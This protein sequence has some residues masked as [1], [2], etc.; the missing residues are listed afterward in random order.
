[1]QS[2]KC[3]VIFLCKAFISIMFVNTLFFG[4]FFSDDGTCQHYINK[5]DCKTPINKALGSKQCIWSADGKCSLNPPPDSLMFTLIVIVL[6]IIVALPIEV[7]L[8]QLLKLARCR[9]N[10]S[11]WG[12]DESFWLDSPSP[13]LSEPLV[14][15]DFNLSSTFNNLFSSSTNDTVDQ[16]EMKMLVE[17]TKQ[18]LEENYMNGFIPWDHIKRIDVKRK[19]K[20]IEEYLGISR[21]GTIIPLSVIDYLRYGTYQEKLYHRIKKVCLLPSSYLLYLF[22]DEIIT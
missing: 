20:I 15:E 2:F 19:L 12:L 21:D 9:P 14:L 18:Y 6:I 8:T 5:I 16:V 11:L 4:I 22:T 7:F 13:F 1:M 17:V 3:L 10:L